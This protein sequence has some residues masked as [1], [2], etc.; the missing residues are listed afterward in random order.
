M[1]LNGTQNQGLLPDGGVDI[2]LETLPSESSPRG[3]GWTHSSPVFGAVVQFW[4][5]PYSSPDTSQLA[6]VLLPPCLAAYGSS[7]GSPVS[8]PLRL[9][10]LP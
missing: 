9:E 8:M 6:R 2:G 3:L 10:A 7:F 4:N 5:V 1:F